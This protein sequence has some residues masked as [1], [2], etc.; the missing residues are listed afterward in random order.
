MTI[1]QFEMPE[2]GMYWIRANESTT[3]TPSEKD[4]IGVQAVASLQD[5]EDIGHIRKVAQYDPA[6]HGE[7]PPAF[8][9]VRFLTERDQKAIADDEK[10]ANSMRNLFIRLAK[11]VAPDLTVTYAR[12]SLSHS[13]FFMRYSTRAE[14]PDFR[15]MMAELNRLYG[16]HVFLWVVS[17]R[18]TV[19]QMG[20][21]GPCGRACCCCSWFKDYVT[22]HDA[23]RFTLGPYNDSIATGICNRPKCCLAFSA[24]EPRESK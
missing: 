24:T 2:G 13:R 23:N 11:P 6:Q 7:L 1:Y 16:V 9:F 8:S 10:L 3:A 20:A 14:H 21:L 18:E 12:I 5:G 22:L 17:P 15:P 4:L 19:A